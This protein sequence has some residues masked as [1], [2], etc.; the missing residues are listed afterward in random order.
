MLE[1][2]A[3]GGSEKHVSQQ[4]KVGARLS[5]FWQA[6]EKYPIDPW[7]ISVLKQGYEIPFHHSPPLSLIPQEFP[8][9][10]GNQEKFEALEKEVSEMLVK[11]AIEEVSGQ[12]P[13]YYNRLFLVQKA[14]GAWRPVLDVSKLNKYVT[15]TKF[16]METIQSVL[17]SIQQ[18][19]WMISMDM[20]DA[21][22]HV[23]IHQ[24][25]RPYLRF[26]FNR[27]VY[28]FKALCFGLSTAPQ[29][30]TRVLAPLGK[31]IH[32]AG[33]RIVLYLDDWLIIASSKAELL[34]AKTFILKL[35]TELGILINL[36]KSVLDPSQVITYLGVV[37]DSKTFWASPSEKRVNN[38]LSTISEFLSC[39][40][41]PVKSWQSLLGH[42]SSLEKFIPGARL[43][44]RPL[45]FQLKQQWDGSSQSTIIQIPQSLGQDLRWWNN[46]D[47]LSKGISL[48][49]KN[50]Q[51]QL[52]SDASREGWGAVVGELH[53][54]GKWSQE[55][56]LEHINLLE[57]KAVWLALQQAEDLVKGKVISVFSDN[58]TAL[59]YI[60]KQGGTKSWAMFDLV[61]DLTAWLE[62]HETTLLPQFIPGQKNVVADSL[63]RKGQILP[64]EWTLHQ[65]VCS[66]L[67][68]LWGQ[69]SI[70]LFA[71]S[72]TKRLPNYMS[73]HADPQAV[74]VDALLQDWSNL[75]LYA[76]PP[77]AIIREVINKFRNTQNSWMT[78]VAPWW[79]QR[80][81][82]PDLIR[83]LV[84][85]PRRLPL[86]RD[87][88]SQPLGRALH[89]NLPMLHL[90]AWRLST[91]SS[92][93]ES[94]QIQWQ[95][96]FKKPEDLL[97]MPST[98]KGGQ[99]LCLGAG[100]ANYQPP[101][102]R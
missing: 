61:K 54:S 92:N 73:L 9:Y 5:H 53:L 83:L 35:T 31:I 12:E 25:S 17:S 56:K 3:E 65:E 38:A 6:W 7:V 101:D 84:D 75:D 98:S 2:K 45:Q 47:R 14:S 16:S 93:L 102:L 26:M 86:R 74:A 85:E 66:Q 64:T 99:S 13:G 76:F 49:P 72:L 24:A 28:Q 63:S 60:A 71:T 87:L 77:F 95:S 50:P 57:L 91:V 48:A 40:A 90:T 89:Q 34:R 82:F 8:S 88:L 79:P 18:G 44:M 27:K 94:F 30:F 58:T 11:N 62:A 39:E 55:D 80:E 96:Q 36:E 32:L 97:P 10:L 68:R 52:F 70:D 20:K 78:L 33:F 51:L 21:Y 43:R 19:D 42:M 100:L 59:S 69:P 22:F 37:I 46:K 15:K 67:W 81:W 1:E 29:V 41:R 23:P 4:L